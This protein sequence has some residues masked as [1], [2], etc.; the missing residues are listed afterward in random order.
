LWCLFSLEFVLMLAA[1]CALLCGAV[2]RCTLAVRRAVLCCVVWRSA[3]LWH[4]SYLLLLLCLDFVMCCTKMPCALLSFYHP[5]SLTPRGS[6]PRSKPT[7]KQ[8]RIVLF[9]G[10]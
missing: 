4:A 10:P 7:H 5:R 8:T 6:P 3:V 1:A 9:A 2:S